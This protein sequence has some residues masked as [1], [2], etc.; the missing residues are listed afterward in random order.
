MSTEPQ[1]TDTRTVIESTPEPE[2]G[3]EYWRVTDEDSGMSLARISFSGYELSFRSV[4]I[5][6]DGIRTTDEGESGF[7]LRNNSRTLGT[8]DPQAEDVP[9]A[10]EIAFEV[11]RHEL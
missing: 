7:R 2:G 10:I 5:N 11:L 8:F 9:Q 1:T 4:T 6:F 3:E